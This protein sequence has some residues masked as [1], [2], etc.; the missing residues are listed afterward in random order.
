MPSKKKKS[1]KKK[2]QAPPR[3]PRPAQT[4]A[5][6]PDPD[7]PAP[8]AAVPASAA[9]ERRVSAKARREAQQRKRQ[10][11]QRRKRLRNVAILTILVL[12]AAGFVVYR[13]AQGRQEAQRLAKVA[14]SAGCSE[15]KET[16]DTGENQHMK[17]GEAQPKYDTSPPTHGRHW[18]TALQARVYDEQFAETPPQPNN[19]Q[20]P[21][22]IVQA[23]HSLEHGY[24]IVWHNGLEDADLEKLEDAYGEQ[25]KVIVV[26]YPKLKDGKVALTAWGRMQTCPAVDKKVIDAFVDRFREAKS[27]PEPNAP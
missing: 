2:R 19:P 5:V 27:A 26:P 6:V 1:G 13:A 22:T 10:A 25:E 3:G 23:V 15:I 14:R 7:H 21:P 8:A 20:N 4:Q 11:Q 9:E 24:I 12:A 18:P 17:P 16:G